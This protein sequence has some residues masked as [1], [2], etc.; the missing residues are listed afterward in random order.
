MLANMLQS[1][2]LLV[3]HENQYDFIK[4]RSIQDCL[5]WAFQFLH[6]C[7]RSKREIAI[8]KLDFE[9][10]FD[11]VEHSVI[12]DMFRHKGISNTWVTW[13]IDIL[14]SGTSQV[15]LNGVPGKSIKCKRGVR[16]GDPLS[17]LL[18][19][20]VP[21]LLQTIINISFQLNLLKHLLSGDFGQSYPIVSY[22]DDTLIIL[23]AEAIQLFTLQKYS[24]KLC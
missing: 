22:V 24:K 8:L 12:L 13:I 4:G 21:D 11:M 20:M 16:Q 1:V 7:H 18:F 14:C 6:I 9:K 10:A 3:V 2:I 23:P 5:A 19:I 15:L 17:P